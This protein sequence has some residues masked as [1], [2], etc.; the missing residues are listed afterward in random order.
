MKGGDL[1][2]ADNRFL[3]H[4]HRKDQNLFLKNHGIGQISFFTAFQF[5]LH[6]SLAADQWRAGRFFRGGIVKTLLILLIP[7]VLTQISFS[8]Y[9]RTWVFGTSFSYAGIWELVYGP[10]FQII[11]RIIVILALFGFSIGLNVALPNYAKQ[12]VYNNFPNAPA[13]IT[14]RWFIIYV[15][16]LGITVPCLFV[17][18]Y[19]YLKVTAYIG[20]IC[21]LTGIVCMII[22]MANNYQSFIIGPTVTRLGVSL[23]DMCSLVLLGTS[24]FFMHPFMQY[25]T[26]DMD[27]P[28]NA[29]IIGLTWTLGIAKLVIMMFCGLISFYSVYRYI[30]SDDIFTNLV[31]QDT[32]EG[33]IIQATTLI[34]TALTQ[35]HYLYLLSIK[36]AGLFVKDNSSKFCSMM[37]G[38]FAA[39][40]SCSMSFAPEKAKNIVG[41]ITNTAISIVVYIFPPI[42][43]LGLFKFKD[44]VWM[45]MSIILL[46]CGS[47]ITG[48]VAYVSIP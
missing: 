41:V 38:L 4:G 17:K 27:R 28:T 15:L 21:L 37:S 36:L 34:N 8:V 45:I 18:R 46:I 30:D 40:M 23:Y 32:I 43:Y 42:F 31:R 16:T 48:A 9:F 14:N 20:N 3:S 44:K 19:S 12:I 24:V 10:G 22:H 35:T 26:E 25:V 5:L 33:I 47:L 2:V 1:A 29:R 39:F 11:P 6:V 7:F 13:F